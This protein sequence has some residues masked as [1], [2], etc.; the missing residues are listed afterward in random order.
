VVNNLK[1]TQSYK[2]YFV[3][4]WWLYANEWNKSP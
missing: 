4:E 3:M 2:C 1:A